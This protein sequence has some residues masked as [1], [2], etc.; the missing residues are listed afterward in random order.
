MYET[1]CTPALV[2]PKFRQA[3]H[4][5]GTRLSGPLPRLPNPKNAG[6]L[7][8]SLNLIYRSLQSGEAAY[9][10]GLLTQKGAKPITKAV[11]FTTIPVFEH[12]LLAVVNSAKVLRQR[13]KGALDFMYRVRI[14]SD[15]GGGVPMVI[16]LTLT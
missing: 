8:S 9:V 10:A 15:D 12:E 16:Q 4:A 6:N 14:A 13:C 7:L 5:A 2:A 1:S 3:N 11:C